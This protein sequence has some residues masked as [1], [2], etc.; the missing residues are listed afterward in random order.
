MEE[1]KKARAVRKRILTKSGNQTDRI[2]TERLLTAI[3]DHRE[4]L[5][6]TFQLFEDYA[7]NYADV[8]TVDT[9]IVS[10]DDY[11]DVELKI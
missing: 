11:Y 10:A 6:K 7:E 4:H 8:L 2:I 1:P 3:A 9:D 5:I